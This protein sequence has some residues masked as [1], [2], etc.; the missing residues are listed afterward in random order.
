MLEGS[1][2][3]FNVDFVFGPNATQAH[4]YNIAAKHMLKNVLEVTQVFVLQQIDN[5]NFT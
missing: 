1:K 4:V 5:M 3:I 2:E